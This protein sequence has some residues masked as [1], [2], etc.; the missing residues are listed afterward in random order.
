MVT[1]AA[2]A[3]VVEQ[4]TEQQQVRPRDPPRQRSRFDRRLDQVPVNRVAVQRIVLPAVAN[5]LPLRNQPSH[6]TRLIECFE[7]H[8]CR[9]ASTEKCDER[10]TR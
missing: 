10:V 8:Q 3:D 7:D 4:R 2:L 6:Q 1:V 5:A 9:A